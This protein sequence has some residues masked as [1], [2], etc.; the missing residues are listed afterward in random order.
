MTEGVI[1]LDA[2]DDADVLR[3]EPSAPASD[4]VNVARPLVGP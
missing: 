1:L 4:A 3:V 2:N